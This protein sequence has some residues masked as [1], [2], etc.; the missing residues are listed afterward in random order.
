M[1]SWME[2][3]IDSLMEILG[4]IPEVTS[5]S[6]PEEIARGISMGP[7]QELPEEPLEKL[8]MKSQE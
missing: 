1:E 7:L 6:I 8:P 4:R 2:L 5:G 3:A